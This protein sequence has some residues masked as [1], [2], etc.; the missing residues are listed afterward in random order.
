MSQ[1]EHIQ[2][3][4]EVPEQQHSKRFDVVASALFPQ[5]SRSRLQQ[6]IKSGNITVDGK[7]QKT[8]EKVYEGQKIE[9]DVILTVEDENDQAENIDLDIVYEDE[10][11][12]V[13]NKPVGLV[14]HPGA[15]NRQGTLLNGLLYHYPALEN[16][17][18]AGVVHRLDKD[19]SGLMVVAKTLIAHSSLVGQ[20]HDRTVSREYYALVQGVITAGGT[21]E[22]HMG[23]HPTNRQKQTVL[24][25]GGKE[26]ITHYRVVSR[27]RAHT[28][29]RCK[30]ETGRT[31][32]IRV[33]MAHIRYP[34]LGDKTYA[35]RP[36]IPKASDAEFIDALQGFPRQA[37]HAFKLGLNH[38]EDG[39]YCEWEIDMA[40]DIQD[41]IVAMKQDVADHKNL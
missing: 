35:G 26:A 1:Q 24:D 10:H 15:G 22:T 30:L 41:M 17:P 8:R 40:G 14:V 2:L 31:H 19:T 21:I 27:Y 9:V 7:P 11:L 5:Y 38:P 4:S 39:Q 18:R 37:L 28:L 25:F 36:K 13:I 20:L 3:N 6:W 16:V 34:L 29:V 12:L 33:H 32:Q 23:R